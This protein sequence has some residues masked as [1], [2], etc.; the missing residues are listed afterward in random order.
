MKVFPQKIF[1]IIR[2][3]NNAGMGALPVGQDI[4]SLC[5]K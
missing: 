5:K 4:P 3:Q 1:P 2:Q